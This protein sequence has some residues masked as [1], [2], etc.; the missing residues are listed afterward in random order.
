MSKNS[1]TK[2]RDFNKV[3]IDVQLLTSN[4]EYYNVTMSSQF[5]MLETVT[6]C[7]QISADDDIAIDNEVFSNE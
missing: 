6:Q 4:S 2:L 1:D 3:S 7:Q 5:A